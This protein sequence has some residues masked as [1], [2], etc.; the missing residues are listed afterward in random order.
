[1]SNNI[2]LCGVGGQGTVLASR[3]IACAAMQKGLPVMS[4]ETIGMAQKGGSVFSHLRLGEDAL[5]PMI[6][7]GQA[8]LI[9]GFEPSETVK[10]LPYLKEGGAVVTNANAI[11][12]VTG[13]LQGSSY[14]GEEMLAY[15]RENVENL[16]VVDGNRACE[17][18]GSTKVTNVVLLGAALDTGVLALDEND[19][20]EAIRLCV[21]PRFVELNLKAFDYMKGK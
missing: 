5:S 12:P 17:E 4:A 19:F 11:M 21:K 18:L 8:D 9:I 6:G 10:M 1:M 16:T 2:L 15:L 14:T 20:R 13:S 7:L 3:L